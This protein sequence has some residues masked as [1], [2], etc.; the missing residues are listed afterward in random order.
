MKPSTY[1][2]KDLDSEAARR[3]LDFYLNPPS[4]RVD[5]DESIWILRKDV[6][7]EQAAV[8]AMSL[9]RCA[10][11]TACESANTQSGPCRELLF[12]LM[13]MVNMAR[14]LLEHSQAQEDIIK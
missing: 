1:L 11:T 8:Q 7:R 9:L 13:H 6:T 10:A 14:A 4:G 5:P 2:E 3:A 12:A